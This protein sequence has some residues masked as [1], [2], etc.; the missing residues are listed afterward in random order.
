MAHAATYRCNRCRFVSTVP[1]SYGCPYCDAKVSYPPT[2]EPPTWQQLTHTQSGSEVSD[3]HG[4]SNH[5]KLL[6]TAILALHSQYAGLCSGLLTNSQK[7][8]GTDDMQKLQSLSASIVNLEATL[9]DFR[10]IVKI[11]DLRQRYQT[12]ST[13]T[14]KP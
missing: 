8:I 1:G 12:T 3:S 9:V 2:K 4:I 13:F 5:I 6:H 14:N 10:T 11:V 7:N